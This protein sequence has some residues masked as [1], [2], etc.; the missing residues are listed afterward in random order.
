M[1]QKILYQGAEAILTKTKKGIEK[2]RIEKKYRIPQLDESLRKTRTKREI[3]LLSKAIKIPNTNIPNIINI[4][5]FKIELEE[6]QG[7]KLSDK[8][9]TY[10][11]K[12]QLQI[13]QK[14]AEQFSNL[15]QNN[16]IHGDP[17]T[18]N[19]ILQEKTNKVFIIDFGLGF[20]SERIEDKA[21]DLHVLKQALEAK[22]WQNYSKLFNEFLINYSNKEVIER[23]KIV[24]ARGRYKH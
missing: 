20:I 2:N 7:D 21:V 24:E 6:I 17:T 23:L 15:H 22:H 5:K 19:M 16:I 10:P 8:L 18:S 3:N 13:M 14:I 1:K 12:K 11:L 9:N 4:D